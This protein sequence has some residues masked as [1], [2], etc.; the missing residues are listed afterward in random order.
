M[1]S[2]MIYRL[3]A[4]L[5]YPLFQTF[6]SKLCVLRF[7]R[8]S[9]FNASIAIYKVVSIYR[10]EFFRRDLCALSYYCVWISIGLR[11]LS[12]FRLRGFRTPSI[13]VYF[14]V[15]VCLSISSF[16]ACY[17][18]AYISCFRCYLYGGRSLR[19]VGC[20][21]WFIVNVLSIKFV[22]FDISYPDYF[23][24]VRVPYSVLVRSFIAHQT[25]YDYNALQL[26]LSCLFRN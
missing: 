16:F 14:I 15:S 6:R 2:Q 1:P 3:R 18:R 11:V 17:S 8:S 20:P 23:I 12:L 25:P 5:I 24:S 10:V 7:K 19:L 26:V 9:L 4:P 22:D 13:N 21:I